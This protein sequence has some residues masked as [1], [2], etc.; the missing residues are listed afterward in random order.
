MSH[1][2]DAR[3]PTNRCLNVKLFG[4][5]VLALQGIVGVWAAL[6][7]VSVTVSRASAS[8]SVP[9]CSPRSGGR[10]Q[11]LPQRPQP[12][13]LR[14]LLARSRASPAAGVKNNRLNHAGYL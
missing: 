4:G 10:P 11:L 3:S 6:V 2:V 12:E 8:R 5:S 9:G 7:V 1:L 14:R 13:V